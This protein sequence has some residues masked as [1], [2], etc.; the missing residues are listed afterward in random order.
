[1]SPLVLLG[2]AAVAAALLMFGGKK[3]PGTE[4]TAKSGQQYRTVLVNTV[5]TAPDREH[6]VDVF[7]GDERIIRYAQNVDSKVRRYIGT[8]LAPNDPRLPKARKD[9]GVEATS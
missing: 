2:G 7:I 4:V 1:M 8:P 9:F 6:I 3:L 5:G